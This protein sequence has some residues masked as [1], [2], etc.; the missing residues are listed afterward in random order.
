MINSPTGSGVSASGDTY[1]LLLQGLDDQNP[2]RIGFGGEQSTNMTYQY[3]IGTESMADAGAKDKQEQWFGGISTLNA[4]GAAAL[5]QVWVPAFKQYMQQ[6]TVGSTIFDNT[7]EG[8][9]ENPTWGEDGGGGASKTVAVSYYQRQQVINLRLG[10]TLDYDTHAGAL[11]FSDQGTTVTLPQTNVVNGDTYE[12]HI[13]PN[14]IPVAAVTVDP[15]GAGEIDALGIGATISIDVAS[16]GT[17][18]NYQRGVK[19]VCIG[20]APAAAGPLW[21]ITNGVN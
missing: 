7:P 6:R 9:P 18:P 5:D 20:Q 15:G 8:S 10:G 16:L 3:M 21:A 11:I 1:T 2:M 12:I 14:P 19:L 17:Y 4:T 13:T